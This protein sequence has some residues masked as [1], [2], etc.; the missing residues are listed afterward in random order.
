MTNSRFKPRKC[1]SR[2][3]LG[4]ILEMSLILLIHPMEVR[5]VIADGDVDM[6]HAECE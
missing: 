6:V 1:Q 5:D 2:T 3:V 4:I